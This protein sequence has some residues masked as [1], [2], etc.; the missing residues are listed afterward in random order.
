MAEHGA[1][2]LPSTS[3]RELER[4]IFTELGGPRRS[5]AQQAHVDRQER[6]RD[7]RQDRHPGRPRAALLVVE[8]AEDH[9]LLWTEQMMPVMPVV[10]VP[11]VDDAPSTSPCE[12]EGG[13]RHT[14]SM[15]S[16]E[17]RQRSRR[18]PG[19]CDCSI[20]VKNGRSQA[21]LGTGRRRLLLLHHRQPNRR[22][23]DQPAHFSRCRRCTLVDHFR[24]T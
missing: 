4:V 14:A 13:Y 9:T 1:Y 19:R 12:A 21:G 5:P 15:H 23:D 11:D 8:V 20:F 3:C 22:R 10:R 18:W 7:P 2:V 6:S 17:R 24:I 16:H